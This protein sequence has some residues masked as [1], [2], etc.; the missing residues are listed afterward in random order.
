MRIVLIASALVL[1]ACAGGAPLESSADEFAR[2]T[3]DCR[4]RG[5]ILVP[6]GRPLEGRPTVDNV[7]EI[8]GGA[9]RI[10]PNEAR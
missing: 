2:L 7:C 9:T 8:R 4:A 1:S 10:S 6:S 5:G 3:A